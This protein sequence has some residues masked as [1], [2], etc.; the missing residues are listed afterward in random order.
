[1]DTAVFADVT[2]GDMIYNSTDGSE[3]IV[4]STEATFKI[5]T[6]ALFGG[7]NNDITS[8]DDFFIQP[9]KRFLLQL[10]P[11]PSTTSHTVTFFYLKKPNPVYTDYGVYEIP[12]EHSDVLCQYAAW[13]MK[14]RDQEPQF[15]D[16]FY[17][18]W[19]MQIKD[20]RRLTRKGFARRSR[21]IPHWSM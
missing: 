16:A 7:T 21:I 20:Y 4:L 5:L 3:G 8:G 12:F 15:G 17:K 13:L 1:M 14:Y 2:P 6:I 11:P 19:D 10:D 9:R 18:Y